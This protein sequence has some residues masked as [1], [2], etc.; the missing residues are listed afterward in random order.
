M[1][2]QA[3]KL[4]AVRTLIAFFFLPPA[5]TCKAPSRPKP[6]R[7]K[8]SNVSDFAPHH[9]NESD[10]AARCIDAAWEATAIAAVSVV[11]MEDHSTCSSTAPRASDSFL[12]HHDRHT[13]QRQ[14]T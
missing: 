8:G 4:F 14:C 3:R 11:T 6:D 13:T 10:I 5:H 1:R 7:H 2:R 12:L 9:T